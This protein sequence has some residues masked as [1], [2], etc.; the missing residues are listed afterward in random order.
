MSPRLVDAFRAGRFAFVAMYRTLAKSQSASAALV[1]YFCATVRP[2]GR[3]KPRERDLF[4][5]RQEIEGLS[6]ECQCGARTELTFEGKLQDGAACLQCGE[7][8][9][10][11]ETARLFVDFLRSMGTT[12]DVRIRVRLL[13]RLP[14]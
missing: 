10:R 1:P 7:P 3:P 4:V 6:L 11:R 14:L 9:A 12:R 2:M 13:R 5:E 8:I